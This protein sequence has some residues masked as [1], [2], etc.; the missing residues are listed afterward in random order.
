MKAIAFVCTALF[1]LAF[2]VLAD[3]FKT[4]DGKDYKG[5]TIS[6]VEPDG[7]MVATDSGIEKIPFTNLPKDVQKK[8]GYDPA[9]A[10]KYQKAVY[11]AYVQKKIHEDPYTYGYLSPSD[12]Y[13]VQAN[14]PSVAAPESS[15]LT[16]EELS[17]ASKKPAIK[18][19]DLI[20][21]Y[22][23]NE[24]AADQ[25]AKG[26][27]G[28]VRG[29]I[30]DIGRGIIGDLY[31]VLDDGVHCEFPKDAEA[32]LTNLRKGQDAVICGRISGKTLGSVYMDKC[33]LLQ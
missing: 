14:Q 18:A 33:S 7:I 5:V 13:V 19:K 20:A 26:K 1:V 21:G 28:S 15:S 2:G 3:D 22:D 11:D 9:K 25:I 16:T 32:Q 31:I 24:L 10:A 8:Y 30:T 23:E 4:L 12:P 29:T 6:R 17:R 27:I